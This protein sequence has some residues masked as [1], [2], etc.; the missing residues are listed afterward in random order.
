[1]RC[2]AFG[3]MPHVWVESDCVL[4]HKG[5]SRKL[6]AGT[7]VCH[8][9]VDRWTE[10]L[11]EI[12]DLYADL[13]SVLPLG[14]IPDDTAE[15]AHTARDGSPAMFRLDAY[16]LLRP[17]EINPI[18]TDDRQA[19]PRHTWLTGI[20]QVPDLLA[21]WAEAIWDAL[22]WGDGWPT[23]VSGA[24]AAIRANITVLAGLPD[25]DTFDAELRWIRRSLHQA[26]GI[27]DPEPLF[28]CISDQCGGNVWP[29]LAGS[30]ACDRC[31]RRY[32]TLD[33]VRARG[34]GLHD[35]RSLPSLKLGNGGRA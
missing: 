31:G 14:S 19:A 12:V 35:K 17:R 24:T 28:A 9:C 11:P 23:T 18:V 34:D 2:G 3:D 5:H 7:F 20:P 13:G 16:A 10:W 26:H 32:G 27:S 22:G 4:P 33:Y 6:L 15:H 29:M 1:M 8:G 30:P 25:V 21:N